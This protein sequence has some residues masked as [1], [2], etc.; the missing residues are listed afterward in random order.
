MAKNV[1]ALMNASVELKNDKEVVLAAVAQAG[2]ALR[3]ASAELKNDKEV[4]LA[5]VAQDG[6][7]LH[8]ASAE[9]MNDKKAVLAAVAQ[10]GRALEDASVKLRNDKE[11]V[12]AAV[13]QNWACADACLGGA[14]ERQG[15]GARGRAA[16][17]VCAVSCL[18][19]ERQEGGARGRGAGL[20]CASGEI[21]RNSGPDL[22][23]FTR[24]FLPK[25][26]PFQTKYTPTPSR[27][28]SHICCL[29]S[30]CAASLELPVHL[31]T[32]KTQPCH[33]GSTELDERPQAPEQAFGDSSCLPRSMYP[34]NY[35][36]NGE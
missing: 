31:R 16:G 8:R 29:S 13:A 4:V 2:L 28:P 14:Q 11:V 9:L 5:A 21:S 18:G 25:F 10:D 32:R 12:L 33:P 19:G 7:A 27:C 34:G 6:R 3:Y 35:V 1:H 26:D 20:A 36:P 24:N 17:R 15:G 22:A 23:K 30:R